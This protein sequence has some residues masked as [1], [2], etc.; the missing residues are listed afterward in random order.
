VL[1][2]GDFVTWGDAS[3]SADVPAATTL[4]IDVRTGNTAAPDG[5]WSDWVTVPFSGSTL[6]SAS[7]YLQ[8]RALLGTADPFVTPSLGAFAVTCGSAPVGVGDVASAIPAS[9]SLHMP[10]PNPFARSTHVAFDLARRG[11]VSLRVYGVDGRLVRT[12]VDA[13]REPGRY[14]SDWDG[15]D[16][17][18]RAVAASVYFVRLETAGFERTHKMMLLR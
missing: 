13:D 11:R 3:W 2:A 5:S 6:G 7:R 12:L 17:L 16:D 9:T 1:D 8:Y 18:G 14:A 15:R 10:S 4:A